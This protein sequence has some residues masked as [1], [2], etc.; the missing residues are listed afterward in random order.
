MNGPDGD[1][2]PP[3][4][5]VAEQSVLG[6]M[7]LSKRA[8]D[9]VTDHLTEGSQF[10]K[11]AHEL[12]FNAATRLW[13]AN[14]PVDATT[15]LAEL[16]KAGDLARAGGGAY[17]HTL[18]AS[19]PTAANAEHYARRVR[20]LA[21]LRRLVAAGTRIAQLGYSADGTPVDEVVEHARAEVDATTTVSAKVSMLEDLI[22]PVLDALDKGTMQQI[23]GATP[24]PDLNAHIGGMRRGCVY[25]VGARPG[26]GKTIIALQIALALAEHGHVSFSSLEMSE[27]ELTL[28]IIANLANVALGR[29]NGSGQSLTARDW[30]HIAMARG[31]LAALP[32]AFDDRGTVSPVDV[33]SHA[34]SVSRK[35]PLAGIVVDYMQLMSAPAD[36]GRAP[37]QEVVAGFSRALKNL[38]RELDVPV[39]VLSQLNRGSVN[40]N[41]PPTMADLRES[42]AVEQD[43]DVIWLLHQGNPESPDIDL[44]MDKNRHGVAPVMVKLT[45]KGEHARMEPRAWRPYYAQ[46][47][48]V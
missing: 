19:V 10:Y 14:E 26:V 30:E 5:E 24:W 29:L 38:A 21:V 47:Q 48:A 9:D 37:R 36:M 31:R 20:E 2:T 13:R 33:R 43:A 17:L 8:L 12:I 40:D 25:V 35:G 4:D 42:G 11:P 1:R 41:R 34:R 46:E 44:L 27:T 32:L 16:H 39:V 45:R 6:S 23:V 22:D 28:R 18:I 15:V 3:H 7:L